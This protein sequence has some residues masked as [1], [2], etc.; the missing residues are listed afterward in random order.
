MTAPCKDCQR[1]TMK[2]HTEC[3]EYKKYKAKMAEAQK[4]RDEERSADEAQSNAIRRTTG[5]Y[6]WNR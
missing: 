4:R 6:K 3:A 5:K 2:C 1:R